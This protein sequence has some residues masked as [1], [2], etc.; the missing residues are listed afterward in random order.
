MAA[1]QRRAGGHLQIVAQVAHQRQFEPGHG[2]AGL[3]LRLHLGAQGLE[4]RGPQCLQGLLPHRLAGRH[5]DELPARHPEHAAA[6]RE[7]ALAPFAVAPAQHRDREHG[8]EIRVAGQDAEAAGGVLRLDSDDALA[9]E[10]E[11]QRGGDHEPHQ[12]PSRIRP[13][14]ASTSAKPPTM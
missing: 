12:A 5:L 11:G 8:Q 10:D 1:H 13:A 2:G 6:H 3:G 7:M 4:H 9:V 14:L